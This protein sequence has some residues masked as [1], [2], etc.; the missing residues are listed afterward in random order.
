MP[1][2]R[3]RR[4]IV[5]AFRPGDA[6][7]PERW[8]W[9]SIAVNVLLVALHGVIALRSGSLAVAAELVHNVVGLLVG[10]HGSG[11]LEARRAQVEGVPVAA[12][13]IV[14]EVFETGWDLLR[15]AMRVSLDA[16]LEREALAAI[17]RLSRPTPR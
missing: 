8:G 9:G 16:S 4:C 13:L 17:R 6:M 1:W 10:G 12:A 5:E 3:M 11:R 2:G 15:D 7:S 14:V